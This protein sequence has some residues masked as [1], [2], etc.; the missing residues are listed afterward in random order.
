MPL[1]TLKLE[2]IR[3]REFTLIR[4]SDHSN[5]PG[6]HDQNRTIERVEVAGHELTLYEESGPLISAMVE[7]IH[8]ANARAWLESYIFAD[9][10]A[11][12]A[13]ADALIDRARAGL[14]VRLMYDAVGSLSTPNSLFTEMQEAG[15]QV[16]AYHTVREAVRRRALFRIFNRRN[17]RKLLILDDRIGYFGGMNIVDQS[18]LKTVDDAK[19]HHLPASAGWRDVHVRMVGPQQAELAEAFDRLWQ[20][21]LHRKPNSWPAW[22]I[23]KMLQTR[24]ESLWFFDCRPTLRYHQ[25][26][27]MLV[28]LIHGAK[29]SITISMAYFIPVGRVLRAL[30]KARRRGVEIRVI[31]PGK[32]DVRAVQ[33]ASRHFYSYLLRRGIQIYERK[34]LML[35]SKAMVIDAEWSVIGSCN[36]DPRSL[37]LNLEFMGVVRSRGAAAAVQR[38]CDYEVENSDCVTLDHCNNRTWLQRAGDRA[39]WSM[40]RWL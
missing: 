20:R 24:E 14:D 16:H 33:W 12:R 40:R 3:E 21:S 35:H 32:S 37:R 26:H 25:A 7:D 13:V 36:L 27:R 38:I 34:D 39:A 10:D 11:G 9:D 17:H 18:G 23:R 30:L 15:V 1:S 19:R 4:I 5:V 8:S 29:R 22:P 6:P 28:P 31:V 2:Q